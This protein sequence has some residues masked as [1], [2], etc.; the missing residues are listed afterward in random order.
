MQMCATPLNISCRL[1]PVLQPMSAPQDPAMAAPTSAK[2]IAR[3]SV[4]V[5]VVFLQGNANKR[6]GF[7]KSP[8]QK[9]ELVGMQIAS[10]VVIFQMIKRDRLWGS[11]QKA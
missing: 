5:R 2:A 4:S 7:W 1:A 9:S 6:L 11:Q 3:C 8:I 10:G